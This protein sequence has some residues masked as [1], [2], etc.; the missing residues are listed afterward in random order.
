M[1]GYARV[2]AQE[3]QVAQQQIEEGRHAQARVDIAPTLGMIIR[4]FWP[5][6]LI[7]MIQEFSRPLIN[8]Y[9]SRQSDGPEALA[10]L[11]AI[12]YILGASPMA[13]STYP[14]ARRQLSQ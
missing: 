10:V 2:M 14:R 7:M 3:A 4:F 5:L 11:L 1:W 6:A 13:G 9:V 12:V 8:L